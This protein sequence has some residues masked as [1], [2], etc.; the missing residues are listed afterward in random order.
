MND[1]GR[2]LNHLLGARLLLH[3]REGFSCALGLS[4]AMWE[5]QSRPV[6]ESDFPTCGL[7]RGPC[8]CM[9]ERSLCEISGKAIG[10]I[11]GRAQSL[12]FEHG[13]LIDPYNKDVAISGFQ[14]GPYLTAHDSREP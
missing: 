5:T 6:L 2:F 13:D 1:R 9:W 4:V 7:L 11:L 8:L 12:V 10:C 14:N 3:Y